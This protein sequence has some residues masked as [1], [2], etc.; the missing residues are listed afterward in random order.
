MHI[1]GDA[2]M[3]NYY[4]I[5]DRENDRVGFAPAKHNLKEVLVQFDSQDNLAAVKVVED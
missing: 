1:L 5:H 3:Q 2:F 4:T